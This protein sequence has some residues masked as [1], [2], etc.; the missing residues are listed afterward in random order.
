MQMQIKQ[1]NQN[2]ETANIAE[3]KT[4]VDDQ[5]LSLHQLVQYK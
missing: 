1:S 5:V 2:L 4:K 3:L